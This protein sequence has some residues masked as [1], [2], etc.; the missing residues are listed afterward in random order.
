MKTLLFAVSSRHKHFFETIKA[1]TQCNVE[2][3]YTKKILLP[4]FK[5][6]FYIKQI[7]LKVPIRLK[8]TDFQARGNIKLPTLLV[9]WYYTLMA[10]FTYII[11]FPLITQKYQQIML[12]NGMTFRQ[13]IALQIAKLHN[14]VP[15][16]V[17]NGF[18]PYRI[19]V[20]RKGV[21]YHNSVP[22]KRTFY[23]NYTNH[24][25]LPNTLIPRHPKNAK[26]FQAVEKLPL[27]ESFLFVPFQLDYDTQI[28]LFSPWVKD[29]PTLFEL[30]EKIATETNLHFVFKEHPTSSKDYPKLHEQANHH[31]HIMFANGYP[32]Q[33]L[34]EKS[35]AVITINSTVGI[36]SLLLGKKVITLGEAFYNIDGIVKHVTNQEEL[37]HTLTT[38]QSWQRDDTLIESFL[39]Y[40]YYDY[41]IEG[42]FVETSEK[43][44]TQ[45]EAIL[46]NH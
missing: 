40:L 8:V 33:A 24:H 28:M 43:Q 19:V 9:T 29:M 5:S 4:S 42:N 37:H 21:N 38:L 18:M 2:I 41:L 13:A 35:E 36:E 34:I 30:L 46:N 20:D 6:L 3:V 11:Y 22:R 17:E 45:I 16:Y 1:H 10:Y 7:N 14:T 12:W 39:K 25:S 31:S 27:P 44:I 26:K 15:I 23:E 32:T